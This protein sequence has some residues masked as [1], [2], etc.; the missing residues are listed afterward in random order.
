MASGSVT[1]EVAS[2][3]SDSRS[4]VS[5]SMDA[6]TS[7]LTPTPSSV[8][9]L[10]EAP[11]IAF[12][13]VET[14]IPYRTG[15]GYA[16]LEF[17]AILVCPR[18]LVEL[19]SYST[20]IRPPDLSVISPASVRCNGITRESV[21]SAPDFEQVADHVYEI[22]H[23]KVWAG[24]NI[25]RFDCLRIREAFEAVGRPA[26]ESVGTIDSLRLLS[27][28]FGKRAG[29]MKM[30]TL[31]NYFGLG[32][33][34]HRS[35]DDVRMN[36]EVV[37]Y[38]ATVLFLES[39]LMECSALSICAVENAT[40]GSSSRTVSPVGMEDGTKTPVGMSYLGLK[41]HQSSPLNQSTTRLDAY[42]PPDYSQESPTI[43]PDLTPLIEQ[44]N[45]D[46]IA[47][48]TGIDRAQTSGFAQISREPGT[49]EESNRH[50]GF[51]EPEMVSTSCISASLVQSYRSGNRIVMLHESTPL[52]L[53]SGGLKVHFGVNTNIVVNAPPSLCNL[54]DVCNGLA[55]SKALESGSDSEWRPVV[56]R[57]APSDSSTIR[58]QIP[59]IANGN[60]TTYSTEIYQKEPSGNTQKL[61]FAKLD[62]EELQ[63][64][65]RSGD[66]P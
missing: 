1:A 29:D 48:D 28:R 10:P 12:F 33:Q 50:C 61:V 21:S 43:G 7:P 8:L 66:Y 24:H 45:L 44:M 14:S 42:C 57:T 54:L 38:C 27:Q 62:V 13:D 56:K 39:S 2:P 9:S 58:L 64:L 47:P 3:A 46:S 41:D 49:S 4:P 40:T 55:R 25:L 31:A 65:F 20:L 51:L 23:G 53:F 26:P 15:Q 11:S 60:V 5:G 36:L 22:L 52:Q 17:G 63:P 19:G 37:K 32:R 16:L 30:A 34:K 18:R 6:P 59:T 35:L